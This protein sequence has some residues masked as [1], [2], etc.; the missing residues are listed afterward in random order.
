M[1]HLLDTS[2]LLAHYLAEPGAD[3]V[4]LLF[5]NAA[6]VVGTSILAMF[7]LELRMQHLGIDAAMRAADLNR[8]RALLS[9][10]VSVDEAVRTEGIRLRTGATARVSTIDVLIA[11]T[12]SVRGAMLV[13]RD[14]HFSAIPS[15]MLAQEILP[16]K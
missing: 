12:A 2:A 5:E 9:D 8:Y 3:R 7:E 15:S 6:F 10:V 14:P 16:P 13:H 1:T 11:A 4:Q